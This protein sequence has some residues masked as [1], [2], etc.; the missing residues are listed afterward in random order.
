LHRLS[1][2]N[3]SPLSLFT[4]IAC[5]RN[6]RL[7]VEILRPVGIAIDKTGMGIPLFDILSRHYPHIE[8]VTFTPKMKDALI[9][10]LSNVFN[11][12]K[13]IIPTHEKLINQL[14]IFQRT[15]APLGEHDDCVM[16]LALAIHSALTGPHAGETKTVWEF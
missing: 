2:M 1:I 7:I 10:M 9:N 13:L 5:A 4:S 6:K 11:N 14:R 15:G 3:V 8:G 12:K 16:A